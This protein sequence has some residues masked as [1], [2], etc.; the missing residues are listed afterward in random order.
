MKKG[1]GLLAIILFLSLIPFQGMGQITCIYDNN[2]S[3]FSADQWCS[4]VKVVYWDVTYTGV[5][6]GL[7]SV[8]IYY[9]WGDGNS[10]TEP[11]TEGPAGTFAASA[12]HTYYSKDNICRCVLITLCIF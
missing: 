8:S 10:H 7:A 9:D 5:E 4:P 3:D 6:N 12:S 1:A 11:A 2:I